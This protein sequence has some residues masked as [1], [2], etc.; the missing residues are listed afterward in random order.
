MDVLDS[1]DV[2][3]RIYNLLKLESKWYE[4][5]GKAL[6]KENLT[7]FGNLFNSYFDN[8]L[9]LPAIFPK[10]DGNIQLEWKKENKNIILDIDI[11]SFKSDFFYYNN[12]LDSD[13]REEQLMLHDKDGW[14]TLNKLIQFCI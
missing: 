13:E 3:L 7:K 9:P 12:I 5:Q 1:L 14:N 8:K 6:N 10:I 11:A 2:S 4:G